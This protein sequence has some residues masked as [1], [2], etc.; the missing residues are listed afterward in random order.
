[1]CCSRA[2]SRS[3]TLYYSYCLCLTSACSCIILAF[4]FFALIY[5]SFSL[6]MRRSCSNLCFFARSTKLYL[7][8]I[9]SIYECILRSC[10]GL[11]FYYSS[12]YMA[13]K[14]FQIGRFALYFSSS[15]CMKLL[16][17]YTKWSVSGKLPCLTSSRNPFSCSMPNLIRTRLM[18]DLFVSD[19]SNSISM[20]L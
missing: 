5:Y 1:M 7:L 9:S 10:S 2:Y 14:P 17:F 20:R 11:Y 15:F 12:F 18:S 4:S 6:F 13:R 19:C 16:S 3:R 8:S